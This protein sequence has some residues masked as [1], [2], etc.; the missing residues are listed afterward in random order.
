M[1]GLFKISSVFLLMLIFTVSLVEIPVSHSYFT[2]EDIGGGGGFVANL[3]KLILSDIVLENIE[4]IG[5]D[6]IIVPIDESQHQEHIYTLINQEGEE[7]DPELVG[8]E[9]L[10]KPNGV[11]VDGGVLWILPHIEEENI[12]LIAYLKDEPEIIYHKNI[13]LIRK[14]E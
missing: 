3:K 9:I 8:W 12:T 13:Q 6:S 2:S 7:F 5:V 10:N 11:K 1:K 4:I 14:S